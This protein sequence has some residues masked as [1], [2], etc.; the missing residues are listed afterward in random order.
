MRRILA[1]AGVMALGL[2][3]ACG[4]DGPPRS[5]YY[6]RHIEPILVQFCAGNV[7]GCHVANDD[8]PFQFAAGNLDVSSFE[9]V[10][11]RR[12]LLQPFG[13]YQVP[14]MLIKAVSPTDEIGFNYAGE[15]HPLKVQHGGAAVMQVGS[16]AYLTLLA[17]MENGATENGLPPLAPPREG[18]GPCSP[19]LPP[20]FDPTSYRSN[21]E[22][23][24]FKS[25]V[26]P[27]MAACNSGNC[28][29]APQ[30]DFYI[31][32]G[33][34][35]DQIA[36]NFS[37]AWAFVDDPVD[38]SQILQVPLAVGAGGYFHTGGEHFASRESAEYLAISTWAAAVGR[39]EFGE[40]DAGKQFFADYVQPVL[41]ERGCAFESC[42][43]PAATNDFKL[44]SGSQGFFSAIALE[45]NY[46][47]LKK[48]FLAFEVPDVRR[49]RAV[50][51]S[52]LPSFGGIGHRG[53]PVLET[54]GS[55][56]STPAAC[57][58]PYDPATASGYCTFQEW[59]N[60][61][62]QALIAAGQVLS[63]D[64]GSTVPLV[65]IQRQASHV[66]GPLEFDTY[67]PDSDL[68]IAT[69]TIAADGSITAGA[70]ASLLG[71]CAGAGNLTVVDVR[72]PDVSA[73]GS[74]VAFAMRASASEPLAIYTVGIDGLGCVQVTPRQPD[75]SGIKQ[76]D[77]DPAWSPDGQWIVFAS[78]RGATS[79]GP[80]MSRK[81][82]LPQSDIW[83]MRANGADAE[84]MTFLSNSE[85]SPQWMREGRVIMT[86]EK[87]SQ[88]FY[89]LSGRRINWDLTD[90][91]PLLAQRAQSPFADPGDPAATNM[92][93]GYAQATEIREGFDGDFLFILSD[94][95]AR[96]GAGTLAI[97][98][99]S[100]GTFEMGRTDP[101]YLQ[102]L[103]LPDPAATGRVGSA[104]NGAYRS[105]FPLLDGRIMASHA[106]TTGDLATVTS[107][108]WD[109]VA[110]NPR[111]GNRE[112][113][114][115]GAGQQV[116][117][118][119]ALKYP[120]RNFFSNKRQLV[121]GGGIDASVTG[122][123][124][125]AAVH[126]PDAP[127]IFTL[128]NANLRRGRPVALFDQAT[129]LAAY[130]EEIAPPGTSTGNTQDGIYES[131]VFLGRT[132]LAGDGSVRIQAP[133][134]AGVI[135]E[136]QDA[137]G[138]PI[139]TMREEHQLGPAEVISLGINRE[140]FDAVCGGCHG[141]VSGSELDV[142]V[143]PDALTGASESL[144]ARSA[145]AQLG[146]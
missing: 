86:T 52:I 82:F 78:T 121:F 93:I 98:N 130:A 36:F 60:V 1:L 21:P 4:D 51:K 11:K 73:D 104:T 37:Q 57:T 126:M 105:P 6:E 111:N 123:R 92:S 28:H 43:S 128:L 74:R 17:W 56:G 2:V 146:N 91:H 50:A 135:L 72:N 20:D 83:R 102:A 47:L 66:A 81:L 58:Q 33:D 77:F 59:M 18:E 141:S 87:V 75:V 10:Q 117:A 90:Y 133:A 9:R 95:G 67:Q 63:L 100:V 23:A 13:P 101:G 129:Q 120:P 138:N 119:L 12:D 38:N 41:I 96:A 127:L 145:P 31:S 84:P 32:C 5:T 113:I 27:V 97:F 8:D 61:E 16:D 71:G 65:Y 80:G 34:D 107:L 69:A 40:G 44:R 143:T 45:R 106:A 136:L 3:A 85:V 134:G 62:R 88:G 144:S 53:G 14:V 22:F 55:G 132:S 137:S 109:I 142:R 48:E 29:G 19:N 103:R 15:F 124:E 122:G 70:S 30:A 125:S 46:E 115:G 99:R 79:A 49:G 26:Q 35:D 94:A 89:Q 76:H 112:V 131:R 39:L 24:R 118:V 116:E 140:L 25:E 42:H 110:V 114:I 64:A 68:R 108:D 54:P 7:A 139:V